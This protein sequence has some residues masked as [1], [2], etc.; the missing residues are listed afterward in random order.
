MNKGCKFNAEDEVFLRAFVFCYRNMSRSHKQWRVF[1]KFFSESWS[2][3]E[4]FHMLKLETIKATNACFVLSHWALFKKHVN[5]VLFV[6]LAF[7]M[8]VLDFISVN[9]SSYKSKCFSL[10]MSL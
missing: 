8:V 6:S 1:V 4:G 2:I 9:G 3:R 5:D 7:M 10:L